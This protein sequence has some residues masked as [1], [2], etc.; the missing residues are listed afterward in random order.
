MRIK[1]GWNI[2]LMGFIILLFLVAFGR[3]YQRVQTTILGYELAKLKEE[4]AR[5]LEE[6]GRLNMQYADLVSQKN[7][8]H[9]AK[10]TNKTSSKKQSTNSKINTKTDT[11]T[12]TK[13]QN[14]KIE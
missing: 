11:K 12:N 4:E 10:N 3:I 13:T 7:L 8:E 2:W 6:R 5:L 1:I 9:L 14:K